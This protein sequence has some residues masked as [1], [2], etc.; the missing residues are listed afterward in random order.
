HFFFSPME[1]ER[2]QDSKKDKEQKGRNDSK[3]KERDSR[4][5]DRERD[6][7]KDRERDTRRERD[8]ERSK[9]RDKR[10]K[11]FDLK[12]D[13]NEITPMVGG[14]MNSNGEYEM[15]IE[16]TNK[17]RLSLGLSP[18]KIAGMFCSSIVYLNLQKMVKYSFDISEKK[19]K[20]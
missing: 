15:S 7:R 2:S 3:D 1:I 5:K 14:S 13:S 20:E 18:L 19:E 6:K 12:D 10:E 4:R 9:G 11:E 16:E 8:N 17:L